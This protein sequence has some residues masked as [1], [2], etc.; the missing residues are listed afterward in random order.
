MR[1]PN[2]AVS[3]PNKFVSD[4]GSPVHILYSGKVMKDG[5][6][7]L[8]E[9]GK[10]DIQEM[11]DSYRESTDLAFI[12]RQLNA[13]NTAVLNEKDPMYGDFTKVPTSMMDAKQ[14]E[15]DAEKEF[16]QLPLEVREQFDNNYLN[17]LFNAG[18]SEWLDKMK[19]VLPSNEM[20]NPVE[21]VKEVTE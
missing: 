12:L 5:K 7:Q 1:N 18:S 3:D 16:L 19:P 8:T 4:P 17:W 15:L 11:I 14:M 2:A 9:S 20:E 6:I 13:G 21:E 10:E